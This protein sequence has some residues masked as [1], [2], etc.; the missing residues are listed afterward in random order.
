MRTT[1]EIDE[2]LVSQAV[3]LTGEKNRGRAVN[4]ALEEYVRRKSIERLIELAGKLDIEDNWR[5]NEELELLR[6]QKPDRVD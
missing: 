4:K 5:E 3:R 1:L 6:M 2:S